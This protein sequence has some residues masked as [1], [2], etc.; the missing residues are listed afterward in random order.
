[1]ISFCEATKVDF[2]SSKLSNKNQSK[3]HDITIKNT[4]CFLWSIF[5]DLNDIDYPIAS[6]FGI[7]RSAMKESPI[8]ADNS[9][10][11]NEERSNCGCMK[12][13]VRLA[14]MN[15]QRT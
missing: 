11:W 3:T 10:I 12:D 4:G 7:Q 5:V 6:G 13:G 2:E 14:I 8:P 9:I 1:M 15:I